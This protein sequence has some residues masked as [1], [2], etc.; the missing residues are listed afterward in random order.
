MVPYENAHNFLDNFVL[1]GQN[2]CV[3]L[4][5]EPFNLK[6]KKHEWNNCFI[7]TT[8]K[9]EN[10]PQSQGKDVSKALLF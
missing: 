5:F 7:D 9:Y 8:I 3:S 6:R 4:Y 1:E 10:W 2:I